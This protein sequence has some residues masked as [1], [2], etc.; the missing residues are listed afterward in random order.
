V[1]AVRAVRCFLTSKQI[2]VLQYEK[3]V[4][5][6]VMQRIRYDTKDKINVDSKAE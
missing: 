4:Y 2:D 1:Y 3:L 5:L 6:K